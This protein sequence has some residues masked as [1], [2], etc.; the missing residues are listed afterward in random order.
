[1]GYVDLYFNG[2][3]FAMGY[4]KQ[5]CN[6]LKAVY[7]SRILIFELTKRDVQSRYL[8][9]YLGMIWAFLQPAVTVLIFWFVFEVGFKSMPVDNYPFVL[10]L[11][12][13]ILPWFFISDSI[14]NATNSIID[15]AYLVKKVVFRVSILPVTK[16]LSALYI[17]LFFIGVLFS[18]F[19]IYGYMPNIYNIQILYYL[20]A[21]I[22]LVLG[23][24]WL[25]SALI[26]FLRDVGQMVAMFLQFG[27]WLTPIFW[28][29]KALPTKYLLILKLNPFYYIIEGYRNT[30]IYHRW[31][32]Q[33]IYLT[34][35]FWGVTIL[36][37][38]LGAF[39]FKKTR[40]HFA[41]VI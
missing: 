35:Y 40:P 29:V 31:F 7:L 39:V 38:A 34:S 10:W 12:T 8:G 22:I 14:S 4:I 17:H 15:N 13:G 26:I 23:I 28:S 19:I 5:F 24:S 41:D 11:V 18:M 33:D 6:F 30:F 37:F 36:L 32:W 3:G 1:M 21:T 20:F 9:S 25:T 27:F 2:S 16:I